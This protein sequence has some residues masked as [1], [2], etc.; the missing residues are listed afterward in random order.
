MSLS[1]LA[2]RG[3]SKTKKVADLFLGDGDDDEEDEGDIFSEKS[4]VQPP[5]L[6]KKEVVEEGAK[7]P[8]KKVKTHAHACVNII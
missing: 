3:K 8:E 2:E 7:P 5:V 4:A 1:P 6:N